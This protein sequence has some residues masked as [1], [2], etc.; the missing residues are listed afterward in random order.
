MGWSLPDDGGFVASRCARGQP[1]PVLR[2][3]GRNVRRCPGVLYTHKARSTNRVCSGGVQVVL[4]WTPPTPTNGQLQPSRARTGIQHK[5]K[6]CVYTVHGTRNKPTCR[7]ANWSDD[8]FAITSGGHSFQSH[9]QVHW[10]QTLTLP[11][12]FFFATTPAL[13]P[14]AV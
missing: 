9:R 14:P 10:R 13:H 7:R 5:N 8:E 1:R 11:W 3:C 12:Q 6:S 2:L 4:S